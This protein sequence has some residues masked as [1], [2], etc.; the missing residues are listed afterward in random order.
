MQRPLIT[1]LCL[2]LLVTTPVT[3]ANELR[4][5]THTLESSTLRSELE[6][7]GTLRALRHSTL[8]VSVNALVESIH[9]DVGSRVKR[10]DLLLEL[11]SNIARQEHKRAQ[12]QLIAAETSATEANRLRDE[13]LRLKQQSHIAQSEVSARESSAR[14]AGA[15]LDEARAEV[16]IAAEQLA[17]H[18]LLAPFDGV[19]SERV[20]DLGQWLN[21]GDAVFTLVSLDS[22]RL[23]V[24]LP[25]EQLANIEHIKQVEILPD[26][27]PGLRIPANVDQLVPV[28]DA[29]RSFLLRL[30]AIEKSTTLIPG[31]SAR[32]LLQFEHGQSAVLL[33]RD[34]V[35]RNADGNH[36]VFV[37]VDGKAQRR[38]VE[39]GLFGKG[40]YLVQQGLRA[41]EQVVTRGNELLEEGQSVALD[42]PAANPQEPQ[43]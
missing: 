20:T 31:A 13:A 38:K 24:Q 14:L 9:V 12:A 11:D 40:G 32:A 7:S 5:V 37:V 42:A 6:L 22:L 23:D 29:S 18:R 39:L 19:I 30:V 34:A 10:G 27:Q 3:S 4:V 28:G 41:G 36:S 8:S 21:P 25:Q 26:T 15:R 35:L 16:Q 1:C 43:S 2:L 33:P 17:K